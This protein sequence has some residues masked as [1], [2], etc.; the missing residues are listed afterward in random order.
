MCIKIL[1]I[2]IDKFCLHTRTPDGAEDVSKFPVVFAILLED[3]WTEEELGKL[4]SN[5]LLRVLREVE[6]VSDS[7]Q[8]MEPRQEWIPKTD[9]LPEELNCKTDF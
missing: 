6:S 8:F 1:Q 7:L 3:G 4:S 5:N 2:C 9:Y